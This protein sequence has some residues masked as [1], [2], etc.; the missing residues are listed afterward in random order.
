[1]KRL[2][3]AEWPNQAEWDFRGITE[4][5]LFP[6]LV[7][8]YFRSSSKICTTCTRW[9]HEGMPFDPLNLGSRDGYAAHLPPQ[10]IAIV[11]TTHADLTI[12]W[13]RLEDGARKAI[14]ALVI[15]SVRSSAVGFYS[16]D[17]PPLPPPP[18]GPPI[19]DR[20]SVDWDESDKANL[21][22][23]RAYL[24]LVRPHPPRPRPGC[25]TIEPFAAFK[26]LSAYRLKRAGICWK[27]AAEKLQDFKPDETGVR[28][29]YA[30]QSGWDGAVQ[31]AEQ[32]IACAEEGDFSFL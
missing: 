32:G 5:F 3:R 21:E 31:K 14:A 16:K 20:F 23:M 11:K 9:L 29:I 4:E 12:P 17:S 13:N 27:E 1:V 25:G 8:E 18:Y 22:A 24:K 7:Y 6:A 28:P 30:Y 2:A 26:W 10:A 15:Q 19:P